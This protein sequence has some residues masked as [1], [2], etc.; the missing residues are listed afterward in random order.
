MLS[1]NL[2]SLEDMAANEV[3]AVLEGIE[4]GE[5]DA[6]GEDCLQWN[7]RLLAVRQLP[8]SAGILFQRVS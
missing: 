1:P 4:G 2:E 5:E 7:I 8:N 6:C 3:C